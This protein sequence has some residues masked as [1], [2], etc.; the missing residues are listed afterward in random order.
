MFGRAKYYA[1]VSALL[2]VGF[3]PGAA[4]RHADDLGTFDGD[5]CGATGINDRGAVVG[6]CRL[7]DG[8]FVTAYWAPGAA[9]VRLPRL[10]E[11][12]PCAVLG[13]DNGGAA[14]G[15]CEFGNV[16]EAA[17]VRWRATPEEA[18]ERLQP[19]EQDVQSRARLVNQRGVVAGSSRDAAGARHAVVWKWSTTAP[20]DLP[21]LDQTSCW[22]SDMSNDDDPVIVGTCELR[23]GGSVGVRW[24]PD[25]A[26]YAVEPLAL[27][28]STTHCWPADVN[29]QHV[30]AGTCQLL[31]GSLEAVRWRANGTEALVLSRVDAR[32]VH[33][34]LTVVDMN[35][36]G[37][38]AG[39]YITNAGLTRAFT[40]SP[41][42][43]PAADQRATDLGSL[44]GFS[45]YAFG[46]ADDGEIVGTA[47]NE[48]GHDEAFAWSPRTS[49]MQ[50]LGNLGGFNSMVTAKSDG[51]QVAGVSETDAG[52]SHAFRATEGAPPPPPAG[53]SR[54]HEARE[55]HAAQ[56]A[57]AIPH[58]TRKADSYT[59]KY[60]NL[61]IDEILRNKR[62]LR[63]YT[64]CLMDKGECSPEGPALKD[65]P[66]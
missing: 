52:Y 27:P 56:S 60:D 24:T 36:S 49:E 50:G 21:E 31:D 47:Q 26:S 17:A 16:G 38:I 62:L 65:D 58:T 5:V 6:S 41:V 10:V 42:D 64:K 18:P 37:V 46:I 22:V 33:P 66:E 4:A 20:T 19:R 35:E 63:N 3:G 55:V 14:V 54:D 2:G 61:D 45:T 23:H 12:R 8:G 51:G 32:T 59:S 29:G 13:I 11:D 25:G 48:R 53:C 15:N 57:R 43:D 30:V 9:P 28:P 34:M 7:A 40:W 39:N 1:G 44:G